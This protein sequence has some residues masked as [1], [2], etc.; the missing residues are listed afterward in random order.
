MFNS[1]AVVRCSAPQGGN[2]CLFAV[3]IAL[4]IPLIPLTPIILPLVGLV[5]GCKECREK[6][7]G[8]RKELKR[9]M[10]LEKEDDDE[11]AESLGMD[12]LE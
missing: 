4:T 2:N 6:Y 11:A 10:L 8:R 3:A 5:I 7:Q 12:E 1:H 9:R